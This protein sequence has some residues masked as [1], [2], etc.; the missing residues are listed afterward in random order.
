MFLTA[1]SSASLDPATRATLP[2]SIAPDVPAPEVSRHEAAYEVSGAS[3]DALRQSMLAH[4][5]ANWPDPD[6][7][8]MTQVHID[9]TFRC[10]EFADGGALREAKVKVLLTVHLPNWGGRDQ[11]PPTLR[12]AW[13]SFLTALRSHEEG[14]VALANKNV[15]AL[16]DTLKSMKPEANCPDLMEHAAEVINAADAA[17]LKEQLD[18]DT[19]TNHGATQGCVL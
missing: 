5:R 14:H 19:R 10:Q 8:G 15:A 12:A 9:A 17:M 11:A 6:G 4:A 7:A 1:C 3:A 13:D 2:H 16:R 18:Y